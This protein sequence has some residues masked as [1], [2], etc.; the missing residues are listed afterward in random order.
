M[1]L[2]LFPPHGLDQTIHV[3]VLI[4]VYVL[5]FFTES[6]GWVW[7]GLVVPGYLAS[8]LV[9]QP[10]AGATILFESI[11]TFL[12]A[13]ALSEWVAGS[14]A[15]SRFFGRERFVL[16]ILCSVI[17]RQQSQIWIVPGLLKALDGE[18]GTSLHLEQSFSSIGLVL[19]P[20]AA[21]MYWKLDLRRGLVQIAVPTLLTYLILTRLLLP[22]TNLTFSSLQLT[23]ENV[24][25]DFLASPKAYIILLTG[26]YVAARYNLLYGWDYNGIL[27]P[28]L[29]ALACF[30]PFRLVTTAVEALALVGAVRL[31]LLL[32]GLRTANL[33]GPRKIALVFT[34]SFLGK[35]L[36]GWLLAPHTPWGD[37]LTAH[38]PPMNVTDLFGFGYLVPSL[39]AAK[40]LQRETIGRILYPTYQAAIVA[41]VAGSLVGFFLDQLAPADAKPPPPDLDK[42]APTLTLATSAG[43]VMAL[44]QARARLDVAGEGTLRRPY[45]E[46]AE[47]ADLWQAA[48][49]WLG[50]DAR[51]RKQVAELAEKR[52]LVLRE[53]PGERPAFALLEAEERLRAQVGW[54]TAVL[55]PGEE[56]PVLEVPRPATE[57]P[58]A[59]AAAALCEALRCRAL[60]ASGVDTAGA[61]LVEG[62]ALAAAWAPLELAHEQLAAF[63]IIQ[64]RA[65]PGVAEGAAVLH[66]AHGVPD[67][68]GSLWPGRVN[69]SWQAPP[70]PL[71]QWER[72]QPMAVLRAHPLDL[73]RFLAE[74]APAP[75]APE[76]GVALE[77]FLGAAF[78]ES[79]AAVPLPP[80]PGVYTPPSE[81]ELRFVDEI[82]AAP[83]VRR[84]PE[85]LP[86]DV[87]RRAFGHLAALI[88]YQ[89]HEL[90]DCAGAGVGCWV[91]AEHRGPPDAPYGLGWGTLAV[92]S[93]QGAPVG[94]EVPRP[95]R[96]G[97]TWRL[98]VELWQSLGG[99]GLLVGARELAGQAL[100]DPAAT[101]NLR[102]PFQ[103]MHESLHGA[104]ADEGSPIILQ[105]RGFGVSQ[106]VAA[107]LVVAIGR[108]L[109][110]VA[111]DVPV[112]LDP[113]WIRLAAALDAA[114]PL[115]W[116][117]PGV[118]YHDGLA[119]LLD[120]SGIG[121]PQMH[122]STQ[123]GGAAFAMLW[124]GDATR[125]PYVGRT[126]AR[127]AHRFGP[128]G[129]PL[130]VGPAP[131]A[132]C[133][134]ALAAPPARASAA[135]GARFATLV[136]T[137]RAYATT[138]N[139]HLLRKLAAQAAESHAQV[140]AAFSDELRLP[141]LLIEAREGAEVLRALVLVSGADRPDV[142]TDAGAPDLEKLVAGEIFRR[143]RVIV[144][145]GSQP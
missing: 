108:P 80:A 10:A 3:A 85:G 143:P 129:L 49:R 54:D 36:L 64:V 58:A 11:L 97:G 104:L 78:G 119:D 111:P 63:P 22:Y 109:L 124:F 20:L 4:G 65:D 38:L 6:F 68:V 138:E 55:F 79:D 101:F 62:D 116:A 142:A 45:R 107:D 67:V 130:T 112:P 73:W 100:A 56:G 92:R 83:L 77:A 32:P 86:A 84:A 110:S 34:L 40:M 19:V 133:Q 61:G 27:I 88:G 42:P 82:L 60:I 25:L 98:G 87:R 43:G 48:A 106:P 123:V 41:L 1:R 120:L 50:G 103:A 91:L 70:P 5:L 136:A 94:V 140:R 21:N 26:T 31:V 127:E 95:L 128:V 135:L 105:V 51:A 144:L 69:L 15:W 137:G 28:A 35:Y 99:R 47:Y 66:V 76:A 93:E 44:A 23:Y 17:V 118:R 131:R 12:L 18:L 8:V 90:P 72:P 121:N 117:A 53:L 81:S 29:L 37:A 33:E 96:E 145:H 134:P 75:P 89:V 14:G 24:A 59:E 126:F 102:T 16:I 30:S 122:Y 71:Q 2:A 139:V 13:R 114:G 9:I 141:Y 113:P 115:G 57:A 52:G 46:L 132:L 39:L 7:S 125:E 74:R